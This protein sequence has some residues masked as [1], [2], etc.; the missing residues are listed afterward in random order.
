MVF[1]RLALLNAFLTYSTSDL[2][3]IYQG[4]THR[5]SRSICSCFVC[6]VPS[7]QRVRHHR[8]PGCGEELDSEGMG[9]QQHNCMIVMG[10]IMKALLGCGAVFGICKN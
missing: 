8:S 2:C 7:P 5:K 3:W 1:G 6:A 9:R 4:M 10:Q